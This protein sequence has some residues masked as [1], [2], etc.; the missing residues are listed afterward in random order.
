M[1]VVGL[2]NNLARNTGSQKLRG[3]ARFRLP[4]A[5]AQRD[6]RRWLAAALPL[7]S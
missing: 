6:R 3:M 4:R 5:V 1:P 2:R 7:L